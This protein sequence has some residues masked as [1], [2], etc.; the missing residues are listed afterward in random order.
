MNV[1]HPYMGDASVGRPEPGVP[2]LLATTSS[3]SGIPMW[4]M[5]LRG[6]QSQAYP[7]CIIATTPTTEM[8]GGRD[9]GNRSGV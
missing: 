9:S 3:G 1:W 6:A 5:H 2:Y 8:P 7:A 4:E